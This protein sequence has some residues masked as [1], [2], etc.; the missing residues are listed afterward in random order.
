MKIVSFYN[1][2]FFNSNNN[3]V[4]WTVLLKLQFHGIFRTRLSTN[5]N[6]ALQKHCLLSSSI[7]KLTF[8][9]NSPQ[10]VSTVCFR[11]SLL[12]S[13]APPTLTLLSPPSPPNF[14][15]TMFPGL[16]GETVEI[17]K[18]EGRRATLLQTTA[19]SS[20]GKTNK[21]AGWGDGSVVPLF[22]NTWVRLTRCRMDAT[23]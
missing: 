18:L 16:F 15:N 23:H 19:V 9:S 5:Q 17:N 10:P 3:D 20:R 11:S 6:F 14:Q 21:K 22:H 8:F 1:H 12:L 2:I 13:L 7:L 4:N